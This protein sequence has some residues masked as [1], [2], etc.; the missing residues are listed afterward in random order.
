M[1]YLFLVLAGL[2]SLSLHAQDSAQVGS[3]KFMPPKGW[4]AIPESGPSAA[5]YTAPDLPAGKVV[6]IRVF[7]DEVSQ[8]PFAS[9]AGLKWSRDVVSKH[10][11]L[12]S[13]NF[14]K[15]EIGPI[16][17]LVRSAA[18]K[19]GDGEAYVLLICLA[20]EGH[21]VSAFY[22]SNDFTLMEAHQAEVYAIFE[23]IQ[24]AGN[25]DSAKTPTSG[26]PTLTPPARTTSTGVTPHVKS[27]PALAIPGSLP[28]GCEMPAGTPDHAAALLAKKVAAYGPES[29]PALI[30]VV[31]ACGFTIRAADRKL[32]AKPL[33]AKGNGIFVQDDELLTFFA[34]TC[35]GDS[36]SAE[37]LLDA[38]DLPLSRIS[39]PFRLTTQLP[40]ALAKGL[41]SAEP[42]TRFF[43]HF[44]VAFGN[45]LPQAYDLST[46]Q[47][48]KP[49]RITP[50]E[51]FLIL[52]TCGEEV[53]LTVHRL[54]KKSAL[55]EGARASG[56]LAVSPDLEQQQNSFGEM[57]G[58]LEDAVAGAEGLTWGTALDAMGADGLGNLLGF[59]N[60][61]AGII[62]FISTYYCLETKIV[63]A[64]PGEPLI[65]THSSTANGD[66]RTIQATIKMNTTKLQQQLKYWRLHLGITGID[67]DMPSNGPLAKASVRWR[68]PT[69]Y[70]RNAAEKQVQFVGGNIEGTEADTEGVAQVDIEGTKQKQTI[71]QGA[72]PVKMVVPVQAM[73]QIKGSEL[74]QDLVD[75]LFGGLGVG[76]NPLFGG[77][78]IL[79]EM[80]FRSK[81]LVNGGIRMQFVDWLP[82]S[83]KIAFSIEVYGHGVYHA[84]GNP[85]DKTVWS[86]NRTYTAD[87]WLEPDENA[88]FNA[89]FASELK[90]ANGVSTA[91]RFSKNSDHW[92]V[93]DREVRDAKLAAC[94]GGQAQTLHGV[95]TFKG[96][97][98]DAKGH[99]ANNG[100]FFYAYDYKNKK[101]YLDFREPTVDGTYK[102]DET[103]T[104]RAQN[105][106]ILQD[107]AF[108]LF[109]SNMSQ[110]TKDGKPLGVRIAEYQ[111]PSELETEEPITGDF[112]YAQVY[113]SHNGTL[114]VKYQFAI[115]SS[116]DEDSLA[117]SLK[118]DPQPNLSETLFRF[119]RGRVGPKLGDEEPALATC[120]PTNLS[121]LLALKHLV[122]PKRSKVSA[123]RQ[124]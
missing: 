106:H 91:F 35:R 34:M 109:P 18:W 74:P 9:W 38:V 32:I 8:L 92:D 66:R 119:A 97:L 117:I 104:G 123:P 78:T 10:Q 47:I 63:V 94:G 20:A 76:S 39:A 55:L 116:Y 95:E 103:V 24:L 29:L 60:C 28:A 96:P 37:G 120:F 107:I 86:V 84:V 68:I 16:E 65:R 3:F 88:R 83:L 100:K 64:D 101:M 53:R 67:F 23:T 44:I 36:I 89:R 62:K 98:G 1:R 41:T 59:T 122:V 56:P 73:I 93:N 75:G 51:A 7:P 71:P 114:T 14:T 11:L 13:S 85:T 49:T 79:Q 30:T 70:S 69:I 12:R 50:L 111:D 5:V 81:I 33:S 61:V 77:I 80:I 72:P 124:R 99:P 87:G 82:G 27:R 15:R 40:I 57:S 31:R 118:H 45:A 21:Y 17:I 121:P 58:A 54:Q 25:G 115:K 43:A 22:E 52:R 110:A 26:N 19:E 2:L 48:G 90:A 4:T 46:S 113:K 108:G 42:S 112:S 6:Q 102:R 105:L